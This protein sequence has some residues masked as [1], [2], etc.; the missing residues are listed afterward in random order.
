[1]TYSKFKKGSLEWRYSR[2]LLYYPIKPAEDIDLD[3]VD[4]LFNEKCTLDDQ[5]T[6]VEHNEKCF[7]AKNLKSTI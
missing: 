4:N 7:L 1:M 3:Q 2:V 5:M 6:I